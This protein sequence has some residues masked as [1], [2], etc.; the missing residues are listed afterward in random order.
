MPS[1]T[2]VLPNTQ[3]DCG[4]RFALL[5]SQL[6]MAADITTGSDRNAVAT[7]QPNVLG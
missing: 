6:S 4:V 7:A 2:C 1:T 5:A 3:S